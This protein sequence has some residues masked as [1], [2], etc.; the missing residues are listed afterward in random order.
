M[1]DQERAP[2]EEQQLQAPAPAPPAPQPQVG[3]SFDSD[4][5]VPPVLVG[6]QAPAA[7]TASQLAYGSE[8]QQASAAN[9]EHGVHQPDEY[10]VACETSGK[11]DKWNES[12]RAGFTKASAW[13]FSSKVGMKFDLKKGHSASEAIQDWFKGPTIAD[14]RT[15]CVADQLDELR[16]ELGDDRFDELFGSA[17]GLVDRGIPGGQRLQISL[18]MYTTPFIDQMKA[19]AAKK[20]DHI[21]KPAAEKPKA[22]TPPDEEKAPKPGKNT[23]AKNDA[24]HDDVDHAGKREL[25]F[26]RD[27]LQRA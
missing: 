27:D 12:Y 24:K 23:Q 2:D 4:G 9:V 11:P 14:Y 3:Q 25:G 1:T 10:R 7:A 26:G 15:I 20:D 22:S 21:H 8:Q 17:N 16:D 6:P 13:S 18:G 19:V 5:Q